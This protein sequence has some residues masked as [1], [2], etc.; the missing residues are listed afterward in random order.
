[1][2]AELQPVRCGTEL[3]QR[4]LDPCRCLGVHDRQQPRARVIGER[5]EQPLVANVFAQRGAHLD[6]VSALAARDLDHAGAE[7]P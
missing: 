6:H 2:V 3:G 1:M 4:V 7:E 5:L